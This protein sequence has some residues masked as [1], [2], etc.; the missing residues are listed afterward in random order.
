MKLFFLMLMVSAAACAENASGILKVFPDSRAIIIEAAE[1]YAVLD[2]DLRG[3][4]VNLFTVTVNDGSADLRGKVEYVKAERKIRFIPDFKLSPGQNYRVTISGEIR[5]CMGKKL[6]NDY[7]WYF[8]IGRDLDYGKMI[9]DLAAKVTAEIQVETAETVAG[10]TYEAFSVLEVTPG[11][12]SDEIS[13]TQVASIRFNK[14]VA[15]E[16]VNKYTVILRGSGEVVD[17]RLE[18]SDR[19]RVVSVF[20]QKPLIPST[21]YMI[22]ISNLI[23]SSDK[24]GLEKGLVTV[25]RTVERG[26]ESPLTVTRT[27]PIDGDKEIDPASKISIFFNEAL[28]PETVNRLSVQI[29]SGEKPIWAKNFLTEDKKCLIIQ[30][31]NTLPLNSEILIKVKRNL[32]SESQNNLNQDFSFSFT[33]APA[34]K[35][36]SAPVIR[37]THEVNANQ[38][39]Q[40]IDRIEEEKA[41]K[42]RNKVVPADAYS[43]PRLLGSYPT[44]RAVGVP[45]DSSLHFRFNKPLNPET[46]NGFNFLLLLKEEPVSAKIL[47]DETDWDVKFTPDE[48]LEY[49][50]EYWVVIMSGVRDRVGNQLASIYRYAF[51][52]QVPPDVTPPSI[53]NIYPPN[54]QIRVGSKPVLSASFNEP[55]DQKTL[56]SFT[57]I[58]NDGKFNLPG[59]I[60]YSSEKNEIYFKPVR[61]LTSGEWYVF[62]LTT[63][64]RDKAGNELAEPVKTRFLVGDPPDKTAPALLAISPADGS[65]I[66]QAKPV[67][68]FTFS[69]RVRT[70][71]ITPF[72]FNLKNEAGDYIP[73][74]LE[75]SNQSNRLIYKL[76]SDLPCGKYLLKCNFPVCDEAGNQAVIQNDCNFEIAERDSKLTIFNIYPLTGGKVKP[77]ESIYI[78]FS[79]DINP[80]SLNVFTVKL[81]NDQGKSVSGRIEYQPSVRKAYFYPNNKLESG[82]HFTL[83]IN[84]GIQDK[85]GRKL[86]HE[87][88]VEFDVE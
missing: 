27:Y 39:F 57:V 14:P 53:L 58:L 1:I 28:N 21:S 65:V 67:I 36:V 34:L 82:K 56:N 10:S 78:D 41:E 66:R 44:P 2:R 6:G 30:A 69:E 70:E 80:V 76:Q 73:G 18:L 71:Q 45:V 49:S 31:E 74:R 29:K 43:V 12:G 52:T 9:S 22:N 86:E 85:L 15:S 61:E 19:N 77:D 25:F 35:L 50:Q 88:K 47:Y 11:D 3:G 33:T 81:L 83:V 84:P 23:T 13:V 55:L 79:N 16:S 63:A 75:Y 32:K 62:A 60:S 68:S 72:N 4:D 17:S 8:A 26:V 87:Y 40:A 59:N 48:P 64:V 20:P 37:E 5:D 24:E 51:M 46:V 7:S 42:S 54:G 38:E